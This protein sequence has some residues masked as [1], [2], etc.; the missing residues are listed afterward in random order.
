[1]K[2]IMKIKKIGLLG[3]MGLMGLVGTM[4]TVSCSEEPDGDNFYTFTGE[5]MSDYLKNR[6]QYSD[7]YEV[8]NRAGLAD[9][10][11]T[12][13]QY[14][15]FAP[16]ND[17]FDKYLKEKGLS[18]LAD[19]TDADCDTI[20]RT[21]IVQNM[22]NTYEMMDGKS[23]TNLNLM[24]RPLT[25]YWHLDDDSV[26]AVFIED[27]AMVFNSEKDDSVENGIMQPV[28]AV[29]QKS[30][31]YIDYL[32]SQNPKISTYF[33][34]LRAT[35]VY[36]DILSVEDYDYKESREEM[37]RNKTYKYRYRSHVWSEVAWVPDQKNLG[38]TIFVVTDSILQAKYNIAKG[39]LHALYEKACELYD[40][41]YPEDVNKPGHSFEN[42]KD[43]VNPLR[44]FMQYHVLNK[45]VSSVPD[46]T[47]IDY[48]TVVK[49]A[50]KVKTVGVDETMI[51]PCDWHMTLL[52]HTM[53]KVEK[54]TVK[55]Y[56]GGG[57]I[58]E[59]YIN[60]RYDKDFQFE[61]QWINPSSD[62]EYSQDG[63][64]GHYFYVSDIVA[65]TED[66][67]NIVQNVRIRMDFSTVFPEVVG[68]HLRNEGT[69]KDDANDVADDAPIPKNGRNYWFPPGY[70]DG[71]SFN[72]PNCYVVL[73]RPHTGFDSWQ[74]DEWNLFGD[75][76]FTFRIP[77]VPFSGDWQLRLG[78]AAE[79]TRGVMQVYFDGVAQGIPLDM[80][81]NID[82]ATMYLGD[83]FTS[84]ED[85][86][87]MSI[88]EK[89]EEQ[90]L[91]KNLG[92]YRDGRSLFSWNNEG[93]STSPFIGHAARY[94]K[95]LC[96]TYMDAT[97]D[98]YI[99]FRVAS[100]GLQGNNNEFMLDYFEMVP[101]SVYG[102]GGTGDME[103]DL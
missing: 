3:M 47:P 6:P 25:P 78:F 75:Y 40:P 1:M 24:G 26:M 11:S 83:R 90:K 18:S 51:N 21:H 54:L 92:A 8:I 5:M 16:T 72:Y 88:E 94:R 37:V 23:L 84:A 52:P 67:K 31:K 38:H 71:V 32:L 93:T 65:F 87:K 44:R 49:S 63:P 39:D 15:C 60:R 50:T 4:S 79:P 64:N 61:G 13:G 57:T 53:V 82:D 86:D 59:R 17:A 41:V 46:L 103:D 34:A 85:Y 101:K 96:Q 100:N 76:D 36:D 69:Y 42:L 20:A 73:R 62:P 80:T 2:T 9:L 45:Y 30:N 22:Y 58:D 12:Y 10:L 14:T 68:N 27:K 102:V 66:V 43:S 48:R 7:F 81:K 91:L 19:L 29:I 33:A 99:R 77:P 55:D 95:I 35:G 97:K 56:V 98:H 28:N 70:L 89:A 74:G